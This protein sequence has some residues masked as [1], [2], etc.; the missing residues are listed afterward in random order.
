RF[1]ENHLLSTETDDG[2]MAV[3]ERWR[4]SASRE[5][6][7]R[8]YLDAAERARFH[9]LNPR[10][11]RLFLL[12]RIAAKDAVRHLLWSRGHGPLFPIEVPLAD[13]GEGRVVVAGGPG[14][15]MGVA[16]AAAQWV[17]VAAVGEGS[18]SIYEAGVP[19]TTAD[20]VSTSTLRTPVAPDTFTPTADGEVDRK[21]YAV[22]RSAH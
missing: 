20:G 18:I 22:V 11:Q 10:E 5:L 16:V 6:M 14:H 8:R 4:D 15:G 19:V 7:A 21:E 3:E 17:G 2:Y 13:A 9:R 1:P 12:G